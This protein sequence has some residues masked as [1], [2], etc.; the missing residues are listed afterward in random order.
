MSYFDEQEDAWLENDCKGAI[1]DYDPFDPDSWPKESVAQAAPK[2][3]K[4]QKRNAQR[5]AAKQRSR[6]VVPA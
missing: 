6:E 5:K 4:S 2:R 1:E 3:M